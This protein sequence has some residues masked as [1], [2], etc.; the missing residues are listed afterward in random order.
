MDPSNLPGSLKA[1]IFIQSLGPEVSKSMLNRFE[2]NE[3]KALGDQIS[4][5][6]DIAPDLIE[7]ISQN[8][9]VDCQRL[10]TPALAAA[11]P[12]PAALKGASAEGEDQDSDGSPNLKAIQALDADQLV[13]LIK[14]EHPQTI[15]VILVHLEGEKASDV[16]SMLPDEIKTD[17]SLRIVNLDKVM[18]GMVNE[19]DKVFQEILK[20]SSGGVTRQTGGLGR[21]ADLLNNSDEMTSGLVLNEIEEQDPELAAEIKQRMFVFEDLVNVD[22]R[23]F[24]KVLRKVETRELAVALK[25]ASADVKEKVYKNM[26]VRAGD[27]LK[28]EIEGIGSL[29]MKEVTDAQQGISRIIQDMESKGELIIT[30]RRGEQFV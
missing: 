4:Q 28:E 16:L 19:I 8:F 18:S 3:K 14:D 20:N 9:A 27:M 30:G 10:K 22:D 29:R 24:Q 11:P 13:E 17:V 26:S 21:L 5:M 6:G 1:A 25:A 15:S 23:G 7:H 2:G 12:P